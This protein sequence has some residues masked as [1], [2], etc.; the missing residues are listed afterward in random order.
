MA[1]PY[2]NQQPAATPEQ[3]TA[4]KA[5]LFTMADPYAN[6]Q[7]TTSE[8]QTAVS[9]QTTHEGGQ[10]ENLTQDNLDSNWNALF[11]PNSLST[12]SDPDKIKTFLKDVKPQAGEDGKSVIITLTSSFAEYEV[13]KILAEVMTRL[14][15]NC[16]IHNLSPKIVVKA[17][18]KAAMPYQSGEKYDAMLQLN[19]MLAELRKTLPDI[20]I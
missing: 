15:R 16:G 17:E 12:F 10:L 8:Q 9:R 1:D 4:T 3:P 19:P 7:P 18:E 6:L 14:R 13:K 11:E 5:A 2:A 20:D